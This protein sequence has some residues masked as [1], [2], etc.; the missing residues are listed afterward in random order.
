ME[1]PEYREIYFFPGA[2]Y[3]IEW[4]DFPGYSFHNA[5]RL[6]G[7]SGPPSQTAAGASFVG[8][9]IFYMHHVFLF[10]KLLAPI[11]DIPDH[12]C[13]LPAGKLPENPSQKDLR[14]FAG[15]SHPDTFYS[16]QSLAEPPG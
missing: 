4:M 8:I 14:H 10:S 1:Q 16:P 13:G 5:L 12:S 7:D 9:F 15:D 2:D 3:R 11:P 6:L